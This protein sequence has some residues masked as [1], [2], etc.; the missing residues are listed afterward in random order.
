MVAKQDSEDEKESVLD[1]ASREYDEQKATEAA[2]KKKREIYAKNEYERKRKIIVP[3]LNKLQEQIEEKDLYDFWIFP[4]NKSFKKIPKTFE[5]MEEI[6]AKKPEVYGKRKI[7]YITLHFHQNEKDDS[8][9]RKTGNWFG[10]IINGYNI[11]KNGK[12]IIGRKKFGGHIS[13]KTDDF[14]IT[15]FSFKLIERIVKL[16]AE[17]DIIHF[18]TIFGTS[19]TQVVEMLKRDKIDI[20]D[21]FQPLAGI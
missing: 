19:L 21:T 17:G 20:S 9:H 16:V 5:E 8:L 10:I 13:W 2:K 18:P 15:K 4:E 12:L 1:R 14:A 6:L 11:D 3:Y 7:V